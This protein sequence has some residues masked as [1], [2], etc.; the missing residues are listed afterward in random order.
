VILLDDAGPA[1]R[2]LLA[3]GTD[4]DD[5]LTGLTPARRLALTNARLTAVAQAHLDD[6]Q[7]AQRR[8]VAHGDAERIRIERDLHDGAQQRLVSVLLHLSLAQAQVEA[9][10]GRAALVRAQAEVQQAL[11]RLRQLS[12]GPFPTV[13]TDEGLHAALEDLTL[14]AAVPTRLT[15]HGDLTGDGDVARAAF[16][17]VR[18]ALPDAGSAAPGSAAEVAVSR[19]DGQL[20]IRVEVSPPPVGSDLPPDVTDRVGAVGGSCSVTVG[21][22][23]LT[24]TVVI[25]CA[26]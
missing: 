1:V 3:D 9:P 8:A 19:M 17:A 26:S 7:C 24:T 12:R 18:S 16:A 15:V 25:P 6:L 14:D 5:I 13:L 23:S 22:A 10:V 4:R 11:A 2:L 20:R 21:T